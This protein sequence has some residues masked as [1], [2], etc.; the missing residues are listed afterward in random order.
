MDT[1]LE[2]NVI[3]GRKSFTSVL[4]TVVGEEE[5]GNNHGRTE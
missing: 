5:E 1:S 2:W 4:R 3:V